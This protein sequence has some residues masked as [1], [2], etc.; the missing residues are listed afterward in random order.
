M[1]ERQAKSPGTVKHSCEADLHKVIR[2]VHA[3]LVGAKLRQ[4]NFLIL[5]SHFARHQPT[6]IRRA[7]FHTR[8][9]CLLH[10]HAA[11]AAR[12]LGCDKLCDVLK[13]SLTRMQTMWHIPRVRI[14]TNLS[15]G[16]VSA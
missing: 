10:A 11:L 14:R 15:Y 1:L 13:N 6:T 7:C 12:A 16:S 2:V 9:L 4:R 8:S 3:H 5:A